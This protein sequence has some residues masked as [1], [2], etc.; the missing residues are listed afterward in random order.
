MSDI[1]ADTAAPAAPEA[2]VAPEAPQGGV[3]WSQ[4][5]QALPEDIRGDKSLE[6]I[7]SVEGLVKSYIHAQK[8]IGTNKLSVPDKHATDED[9]RQ[10]FHKLGVPE[11]VEEYKIDAGG[12][13]LSEEFVEGFRA[14]AH[15]AG[16]L[17]KQATEMAKWYSS[18]LQ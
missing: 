16:V 5:K 11:K 3:D 12:D 9:W 2:P 13:V 14:Q 15:K 10:V 6:P 1:I 17:P 4:L 7:T 18:F 8:A